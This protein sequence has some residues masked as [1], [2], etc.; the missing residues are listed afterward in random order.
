MPFLGQK[1]KIWTYSEYNPLLPNFLPIALYA[2][3]GNLYLDLRHNHMFT[4]SGFLP[5]SCPIRWAARLNVFS[6]GE[7]EWFF[8]I[9]GKP[10][11][12]G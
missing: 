8:I 5:V 9:T 10:H 3:Q 7:A 2:S 6:H 12:L 4:S 11:R 1:W